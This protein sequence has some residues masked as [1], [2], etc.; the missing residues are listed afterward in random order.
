[1]NILVSIIM[2]CFNSENTISDSIKSIQSQTYGNWE[3]LIVDDNSSDNTAQV[4]QKFLADDRILLFKTQ[5]NKGAGNARNFGLEKSTGDY[6]AFCDSDDTWMPEKL[7]KQMR[8]M[9]SN[10]HKIS[11]TSYIKKGPKSQ[12]LVR[13][14]NIIT[15]SDQLMN[16]WLGCL[17]V[18]YEKKDFSDLRFPEIRKRQDWAMWLSLLQKGYNAYS[19]SEPLAYYNVQPGSL[20]TSSKLSLVKYTWLVYKQCLMFSFIKSLRFTIRF[21]W[22]QIYI[23]YC[24]PP[25]SSAI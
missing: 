17:T 9:I 8:F 14:N 10:G 7:E 18:V 22:R 21:V 3:L 2:P 15:Y 24:Q 4:V 11:F 5:F 19:I 13:A 1:M 20:T 12:I 23:R 16:N 25:R 6:V